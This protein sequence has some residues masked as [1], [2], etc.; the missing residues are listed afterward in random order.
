MSRNEQNTS[1]GGYRLTLNLKPA[2]YDMLVELAKDQ[3][4]SRSWIAQ[5]AIREMYERHSTRNA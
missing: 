4:R 5:K 3:D 1:D 2:D